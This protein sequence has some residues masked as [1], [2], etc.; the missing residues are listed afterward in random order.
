[1]NRTYYTTLDDATLP[2]SPTREEEIRLFTDFRTKRTAARREHLVRCYLRFA[3]RLA[4]KDLKRRPEHMRSRAGMSED[5]S[6]SAANLGLVT[7]IERFDPSRGFRFTTYAGF[8]IY[9]YLLE[10][11]YGAHLVSVTDA[12][13]RAFTTLTK[14]RRKL[15][16]SDEELAAHTGL[17]ED[18]VARLLRLPFG[19]THSIDVLTEDVGELAEKG[20]FE[21][22]PEANLIDE[23]SPR[24]ET[25]QE[26]LLRKLPFVLES[27]PK[28]TRDVV[29]D[30]FLKGFRP[31][32]IAKRHR[33]T[34]YVVERLLAD[35]LKALRKK[36]ET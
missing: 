18:E 35:G 7:A 6:I 11:R 20:E 28:L 27:L 17:S 22:A 4:R 34:P 21:A 5:D 30:R 36:L 29:S 31:A 19:R 14:L 10:A 12:E 23:E 8:W 3:L 32:A 1:M 24:T 26:E 33:L 13:K 15:G 16:L 25:E 9:K 2:A